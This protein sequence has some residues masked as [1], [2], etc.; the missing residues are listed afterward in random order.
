M[1][2]IL[3][4]S[5]LLCVLAGCSRSSGPSGP[6]GQ[7]SLR[8]S[9]VDAPAAYSS[10]N[11]VVTEVSVHQA[12]ADASSGWVVLDNSSKTYDLLTLTNGSVAVIAE[13]PID[14][15]TYSQV[16]LK[17]GAGSYVVVNGVQFML[18]VSS[19]SECT[20]DHSFTLSANSTIGLTL[21]FNAAHSIQASGA[22]Q[23]KLVPAI[24]VVSDDDEGSVSGT[25]TPSLAK[26]VISTVAGSDTISTVADSSTG[27][28]KLMAVPAGTYSIKIHPTASVYADTVI[29]GVQ[30]TAQQDKSLGAINLRVR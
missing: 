29:T 15:G 1:K 16:R 11:I 2:T 21:D 18:D 25:V 30:V 9:M 20:L 22:V 3:A 5:V 17:L 26:P 10:V 12:N 14:A 24:R 6:S 19:S 4:F 13:A 28:F 27:T 7:G 23:F 8:I